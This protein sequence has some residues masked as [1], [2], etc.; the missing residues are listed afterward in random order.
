MYQADTIKKNR[1][2][3]IID[4]KVDDFLIEVNR[5]LHRGLVY[6]NTPYLININNSYLYA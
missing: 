5:E 4:C 3:I 6:H 2:P 1:M